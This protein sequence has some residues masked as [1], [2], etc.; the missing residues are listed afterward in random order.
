MIISTCSFGSTGSSVITDY[1]KE[2]NNIHVVDEAEL[3]WIAAVD[4]IIDLDYHLNNNHN[5]TVDSICAIDRYKKLCNRKLSY[6]EKCGVS[7]EIFTKSVNEFLDAIIMASWKWY[8][9]TDNSHPLWERIFMKIINKTKYINKWQTKTK[10]Q[11]EGFPY[12]DVYFSVNPPNFDAAVKKH[13]NDI[14]SALGAKNYE[15]LAF[16]QLFPGN[17]PQSC[18]KYFDDPYAIVV[19]RDP[20]DIYVFGRTNII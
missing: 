1:L 3:S 16:D 7:R 11:W 5:R 20:R 14:I 18:F 8:N 9:L 2:F 12:N 17:N 15:H 4:G 13:I 10:Q 6:F 19:D